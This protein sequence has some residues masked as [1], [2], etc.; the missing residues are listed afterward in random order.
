MLFIVILIVFDQFYLSLQEEIFRVT[1]SKGV[2]FGKEIDAYDGI[3]GI[4]FLGVPFAEPPVGNLRFRKPVPSGNWEGE[5]NATTYRDACPSDTS[6]FTNGPFTMSEDCLHVNVFTNRRCLL[7]VKDCPV[8]A[9]VHGGRNLYLSPTALWTNVTIHNWQSRDIVVVN[10]GYRLGIFGFFNMHPFGKGTHYDTNVGLWDIIEALRWIRK[11]ISAFGGNP[12]DVTLMGHS[13]GGN[14]VDVLSLSPMSSPLFDKQILMSPPLVAEPSKFANKEVIKIIMNKIGCAK[15]INVFANTQRIFKMLRCA[16]SKSWQKIRDVQ[17]STNTTLEDFYSLA[18]DGE[19][20]TD[21]F[22]NRR[23]F[24][25]PKPALVGNV[26][27]ETRHTKIAQDEN[28]NPIEE[29]VRDFCSK[30]TTLM[31]YRKTIPVDK[32]CVEYYLRKYMPQEMTDDVLY[33]RY[34]ASIANANEPAGVYLYIFSYNLVGQASKYNNAPEVSPGHAED[35]TYI[36]KTPNSS[37]VIFTEKDRKIQW[38]YTGF[39][40]NFIRYGD[41][42]KSTPYTWTKYS[43]S[44]MNYFDI[45]FDDN[46]TMPQMREDFHR[47]AHEFWNNYT[48]QLGESFETRSDYPPRMDCFPLEAV[49]YGVVAHY[50]NSNIAFDK[51]LPS[52]HDFYQILTD[53]VDYRRNLELRQDTIKTRIIDFKSSSF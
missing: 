24:Q 38:V 50:T 52:L 53:Y 16:R 4:T 32:A 34:S 36:S 37:N 35:Y 43:S 14:L 3:R 7:E 46:F 41:P 45:Y 19:L 30:Y 11:E 49:P 9:F 18:M 21:T 42:S 20:I 33:Y 5:L 13:S 40:A 8:M 1:T 47:S 44:R 2:L 48:L 29:R 12:L 22:Y 6:Y 26:A 23:K 28:G 15:S 31:G 10:I 27:K 17:V 39:F 25:T 51:L